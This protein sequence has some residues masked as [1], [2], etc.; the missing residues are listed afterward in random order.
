[1][2]PRLPCEGIAA[3]REGG[4]AQFLEFVHR[5]E[6]GLERFLQVSF[7]VRGDPALCKIEPERSQRCHDHHDGGE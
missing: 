5:R 2:N 3:V 4:V 1:M 7:R 6:L